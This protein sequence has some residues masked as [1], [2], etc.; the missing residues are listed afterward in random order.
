MDDGIEPSFREG[1]G[2]GR[3]VAKITL[4]HADA[5]ADEAN[6]LALDG[7]II[8]VV[9]AVQ[10]RNLGALP[11]EQTLDGVGSNEAGSACDQDSHIEK[12]RQGCGSRG[13]VQAK[14][15]CARLRKQLTNGVII[16]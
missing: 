1:F 12:G 9:E 3:G 2:G 6:V 11:A 10:D 8:E 4:D 14:V 13:G 7:R 16:P 5:V 15:S